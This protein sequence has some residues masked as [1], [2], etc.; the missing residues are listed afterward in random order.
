MGKAMMPRWF[1]NLAADW[2]WKRAA[3]KYGSSHK[4]SARPYA[5]D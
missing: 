4:L 1:Y 3:K 2:G 5:G